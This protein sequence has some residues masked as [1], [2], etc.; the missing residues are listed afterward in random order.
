MSRQSKREKSDDN[1]DD[2][3]EDEDYD[4]IEENLGVKVERVSFTRK[5]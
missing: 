2:R 1:F 3:V 5:M 4:L